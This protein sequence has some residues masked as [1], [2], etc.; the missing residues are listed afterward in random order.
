MNHVKKKTRKRSLVVPHWFF[1]GVLLLGMLSSAAL[2][3][4]IAEQRWVG[5]L[6]Q[7]MQ[8][9]QRE[10]SD[11]RTME[12]AAVK[13]PHTLPPKPWARASSGVEAA[14]RPLAEGVSFVNAT[15]KAVPSVVHIRILRDLSKSF[16]FRRFFDQQSTNDIV[17]LGGGSGVIIDSKGYIVT[18]HHVIED[19]SAENGTS[20]EV[21]LNDNRSFVGELV[22][23]D[24]STDLALVRVQET[25][26]PAIKWGDS[27]AL[28]TGAWVLAVGNP[29]DLRSTVT[30]GI[31]SAKGRNIRSISENL[32]VEAF[33]QTDAVVN[34]GNSGGGLVNLSGELVGITTAIFTETG[35]YSGYSFAVPSALVSK[36]VDDL[37]AYGRVERAMLGVQIQDVNASLARTKD[38]GVFRG[39]WIHKVYKK[40]AAARAGLLAEDV[41]MQIEGDTIQGVS[42]LQ[43]RV[44]RCRPGEKLR[45]VV[46]RKGREREIA[47]TLMNA[48]E[49]SE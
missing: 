2:T 43:E 7:Q 41:I 34:R 12:T 18:N 44:A 22:G 27:D 23:S 5:H 20:I 49:V 45:L 25:G 37:R 13:S 8:N 9:Q 4:F 24:P 47:V 16:R 26:L 40:S 46:L 28:P 6:K 42:Q 36:I 33:I 35:V 29:F 10:I 21:V 17:E 19:V 38:L 3:Y 14:N 31:V 48:T 15:K 30:A 1:A 11:A 32:G 39:V